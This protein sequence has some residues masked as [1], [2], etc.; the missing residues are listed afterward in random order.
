MV[1]SECGEC[2]LGG[3]RQKLRS[4]WVQHV[5]SSLLGQSGYHYKRIVFG[6]GGRSLPLETK[7]G[8]LRGWGLGKWRGCG[9]DLDLD[10]GP[11]FGAP[12][13]F[14]TMSLKCQGG[15]H[16][17]ARDLTYSLAR[18]DISKALP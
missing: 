3:S 7:R 17:L 11:D 14:R 13:V 4:R 5:S 15:T 9:G 1:C 8:Q 18:C 6:V 12:I 2:G 10:L 16:S